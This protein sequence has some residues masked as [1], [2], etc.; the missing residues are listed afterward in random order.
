MALSTT[1]AD[2]RDSTAGGAEPPPQPRRKVRGM[3]RDAWWQLAGAALAGVC[4]SLLFQQLTAL[5][6]ALPLVLVAYLLFVAVYA[7]LVSLSEDRLVVRDAVM[8]VLMASCAVLALGALGVVVVFTLVKGW[9]ALR[10]LNFYTQDMS[11]AGPLASLKVGG[12]GHALVG[13]MWQ[14]GIATVLTVPIGLVAAVYL[15][16]TRSR[17]AWVFRTVVE[18]MTAM[19]GILAGLFIFCTWLLIL[20]FGRSGLAAALALS[21]MMLPYVTRAADLALRLVPANLRE[22]ASAL[23][24]PSWRQEFTVVLPTARSGLATAV[25]LGVARAIGEASPVLLV[26]GF[27]PYINANPLSGPMVSLPLE[28]LQLVKAGIPAYTSRAF[29]CGAFLLVVVIVLFTIAR[30]IGGWGPGHL[31][32][33][34]ERRVAKGSAADM[35]RFTDRQRRLGVPASSSAD[36]LTERGLNP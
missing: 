4:G 31:S 28:T 25:I 33:R 5:S 16:M 19:P 35:V 2:R 8:T 18:A 12:V 3:R 21:V 9:P 32:R 36:G 29:G 7:A 34:G 14:V 20:G 22:A 15:D 11:R 30:R 10:H 17:P 26:A 1:I 13:T 23:G 6:G 24:A 27:T